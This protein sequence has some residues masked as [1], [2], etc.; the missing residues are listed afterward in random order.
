MANDFPLS[1][2]DNSKGVIAVAPNPAVK[3]SP[4]APITSMSP[5]LSL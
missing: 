5:G 1:S 4:N 2:S 3:L